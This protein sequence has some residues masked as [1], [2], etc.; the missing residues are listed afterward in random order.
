MTGTPTHTAAIVDALSVRDLL[1]LAH[2]GLLPMFNQEQ[3]LFCFRLNSTAEGLVQ[4]G[5]SERYSA[6]SLLGLQR[7][8]E[9]DGQQS[10][11]QIGTACDRLLDDLRWCTGVGDAGLA[12]WLC[13]FLKPS[14]LPEIYSRLSFTTLLDTAA[15]A[16]RRATMELAWC[17]TGLSYAAERSG[18]ELAGVDA[19]APRAYSMLMANQGHKGFFGH[20]GSRATL[21]GRVRG[22]IGSFADQVYPIYALSQYG[23]VFGTRTALEK[24]RACAAAICEAQGEL[25]QWWWH[26]DA[27][28][29]R[30]FQRYPVYS[31]HQEAMAPMALFAIEA[32]GADFRS[33]LFKGLAWIA[34]ANELQLDLRETEALLVWR[35]VYRSSKLD[36]LVG[37]FAGY[38]APLRRPSVP[39]NLAVKR[40]CRPYELGW[41][42]YAFS[43][44]AQ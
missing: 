43:G 28:N 18:A 7:A 17:V 26:Y 12:L 15:D 35:S 31:V 9:L 41:L 22:W 32:S 25:G 19:V 5:I 10:A 37:E 36:S 13:A 30:V 38:M 14:R 8:Q 3:G 11:I 34:G 39:G 4:E 23:R 24:G 16:Q 20:L 40:E 1:T 21:S 44:R 27:S 2:R 6:M 42:L 33:A 29:G